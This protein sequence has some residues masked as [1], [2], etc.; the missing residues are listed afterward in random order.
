[1]KRQNIFLFIILLAIFLPTSRAYLASSMKKPYMEGDIAP[2][3]GRNSEV[4]FY[5]LLNNSGR[6]YDSWI[7][8][9]RKYL[10]RKEFEQAIWAFRKAVKL[11]P[12][13]EEARFLLGWTYE[14]RGLEGLPGDFTNWDKLAENEYSIAIEVADHLPSRFN[15]AILQRR[16][17][18]YDEARRNL[19]HILLVTTSKT[20]KKR[21]S[22]ELQA[23]FHQD[24]RPRGISNEVKDWSSYEK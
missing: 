15:L 2:I 23:L 21:A 8:D 17:E 22:A 12:A 11:R 5:S 1:M 10:K 13:A 4:N 6:E 24:V 20:M 18:R 3:Y 7:R 16:L 14:T 19:E 9:G